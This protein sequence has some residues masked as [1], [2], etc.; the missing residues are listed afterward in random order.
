[1]RIINQT[2]NTI[3]AQNASIAKT[4]FKRMK[5]LLGRRD[6]AKGQALILKPGNSVHTFFMRFPIDVLFVD[7]GN[8]II[9]AENYLKPWRLTRIWWRAKFVIELPA[10]VLLESKTSAGDQ[11]SLD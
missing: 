4:A 2:K 3:L 5:G 6:F 8:K 11:I 1:M 10:G 9:A 7:R